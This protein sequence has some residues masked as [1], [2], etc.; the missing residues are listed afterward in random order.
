MTCTVRAMLRLVVVLPVLALVAPRA[1]SADPPDARPSANADSVGRAHFQ[2]G[3]KLSANGQYAAAYREFA[4]GYAATKRPLFL[5]N[6]AEAARANGDTAKARDAY[7]EFLRADP[8]S[9]LA[10]TART[11]L[12]EL[13]RGVGT[14]SHPEATPSPDATAGQP[15]ASATKPDGSRAPQGSPGS[16]PSI[17]TGPPTEP[18][19]FMPP[20]VTRPQ[21]GGEGLP[22]ERFTAEH[23]DAEDRPLWKKWPFWAAVGGVVAGGVVVFAVT[24]DHG[25]ACGPGCSEIDFRPPR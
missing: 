12:A 14:T 24:R 13:E 17:S 5:F 8:K 21:P 1:A 25:T 16:A 9:A 19:P 15:D 2:R 18:I 7:L 3:Q 22:P 20:S 4:A 23:R 11:R 10:A 6:M